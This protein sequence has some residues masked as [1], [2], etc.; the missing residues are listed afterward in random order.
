MVEVKIQKATIE[1]LKDIQELNLLLFEKEY[2]EYDKTLNLNW[3]FGE[4]GTKYFK[5]KISNLDSFAFV[6]IIN[7]EIVGY[8]V[9]GLTKKEPY[10][11]LSEVA[12]LDNM[13]ILEN[14]R[15]LRIGEKLYVA[16]INWCKSKS[17]KKIR[18][19][20]SAQNVKAINFYKKRDLKEHYI[21]L[22]GDIK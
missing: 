10:R 1:N 16:F 21:T 9:G 14:Y 4:E 2:E 6:S 11:N 8:L 3:T 13:L 22:E 15:N 5:N 7:N 18:V 20:A 19:V 17:V 12:E